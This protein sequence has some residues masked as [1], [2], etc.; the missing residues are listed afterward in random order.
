MILK[1]SCTAMC[2]VGLLC[3]HQNLRAQ[4]DS[5]TRSYQKDAVVV[6]GTRAE[7]ALVDVPVPLSMIG[8]EEMR[9]LGS[10]RLDQVLG[11]QT[12]LY[13]QQNHGSGIQLQGLAADYTLILLDGEPIIGRTAGTLDL[14]RLPISNL[15]RVEVLKGPA[16]ALYG[17]DALGG[18]INL[19]TRKTK[20]QQL[21]GHIRY[22]SLGTAAA[23]IHAAKDSDRWCLS[24][25]ADYQQSQGLQRRHE[26]GFVLAPY[27]QLTLEPKLDMALSDAVKLR[28]QGRL[29]GQL[30]NYVSGS[31]S[32][33]TKVDA[34]EGD[35]THSLSL[36]YKYGNH[37]LRASGYLAQYAN[38]NQMV[39]DNGLELD[40]SRFSQMLARLEL[41]VDSYL[42]PNMS[43][44]SGLGFNW[45]QVG[46][47]RY[48][49]V[50]NQYNRYGFANLSYAPWQNTRLE[51]GARLD[52]H[53]AFGTQ[54]SPKLA[55]MQHLAEKRLQVMLNVARG[56]KAP[57]FRQ[58]YLNFINN[59]A[60]YS[61]FGT[62]ELGPRL[63]ELVTAGQLANS[64]VQDGTSQLNPETAVAWNMGMRWQLTPSLN[65]TGNIFHNEIS[66]LIDT[67]VAAQRTNGQNIFSYRN[68][69]QAYTQGAEVNFSYQVVP[70][71]TIAGGYQYLRT[72]DRDVEK[73]I[74]S[75]EVFT[76]NPETGTT[77]RLTIDQYG[78]LF[79]R[80]SHLANLRLF[81]QSR[82]GYGATVRAIYTGQYGFTDLNGNAVLDIQQEYVPG[83]ALLNA[84]V[85]LPIY[86]KHLGLQ[87]GCDNLLDFTNTTQLAQLPGRLLWVMLRF[88]LSKQ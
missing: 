52:A 80:P 69:G 56:F 68:I 49:Q 78:G 23:G 48:S 57:D 71:L 41:I 22:G 59:V 1:Y 16:S 31:G 85:E 74:E 14:K 88:Q 25:N 28:Y 62:E 34:Q 35:I 10:L 63:Q 27:R 42:S 21:G 61:V 18:V 17:S 36:R 4:Q 84:S 53:S 2:W 65:L 33:A 55:V 70:S 82:T 19:I 15:E 8:K 76:R 6:T 3:V 38:R 58:Q 43:L 9:Q 50:H 75:R 30:A 54:L 7:R 86:Q 51:A 37:Q 47:S 46:A 45:E 20:G 29:Q 40:N 32:A 87:A 79:N 60:G 73:R 26:E 12:G 67:Y 66:N 5:A 83:Y 44:V 11:E 72:G 24:L 77:T 39:Q 64:F 81:W 13:I